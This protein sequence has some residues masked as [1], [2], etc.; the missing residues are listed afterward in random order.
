MA[1]FLCAVH[2]PS[3]A[4]RAYALVEVLSDGDEPATDGPS[5][6]VRDLRSVAVPEGAEGGDPF[7]PVLDV[8]ASEEQYAAQ[9][10]FVVTGGQ[11]AADA[12]HEHGPSAAAV[13]IVGE[14]GPD[15]DAADVSVQVLVDTFERLYRAGAVTVPGALDAASAAVDALY[16]AAD[17]EAAAPGSDRG[18]DGDLGTGSTT[19]AG[20]T[21]PGDGPSP[22]VVEQS[23]SAA[24]TSTERIESPITADEATAM[25]VDAERRQGRVAASTGAPAPD[26]GDAED[27]ALALA[28]AC[29]YGETSRDNLPQTDKADEALAARSKRQ[30]QRN[31]Q[32]S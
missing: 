12:L 15:T 19:L 27:V 22:T 31:P 17:L 20:T 11:R 13:T 21:V 10:T 23:G 28:L 26:L 30:D 6:V 5:Y 7:R 18:P 32:R 14:D 4:P 25:A 16:T 3:A 2:A 9:T 8:V 29:W 24:N 1:R